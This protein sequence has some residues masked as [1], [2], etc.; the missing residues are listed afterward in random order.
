MIKRRMNWVRGAAL[1]AVLGGLPTASF[2][3]FR[4]TSEQRSACMGDA[5]RLCSSDIPNV[6]RIIDCL[7]RQKDKMSPRCRAQFIKA[8]S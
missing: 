5:L 3:E 1:A 6:N 4:P 7:G 8:A 2:A